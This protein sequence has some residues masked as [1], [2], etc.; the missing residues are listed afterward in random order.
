[1]KKQISGVPFLAILFAV[2]QAIAQPCNEYWFKIQSSTTSQDSIKYLRS[3][4]NSNCK[5]SLDLCWFNLARINYLHGGADSS[6]L[7]HINEAIKIDSA[8]YKYFMLRGDIFLRFHS[9]RSALDDYRKSLYLMRYSSDEVSKALVSNAIGGTLIDISMESD[10]IEKENLL[11]EAILHLNQAISLYPNFDYAYHLLGVASFHLEN[12]NASINA[13]E[14]CRDI[15][16]QREHLLKCLSIAYQQAG[17]F[18]GEKLYKLD[19]AVVLLEKAYEI[20]SLDIETIRL[21]GVANG[22]KGNKDSALF[23]FKKRV[24]LVPNDADACWDLS[25]AYRELGKRRAMKKCK[26]KRLQ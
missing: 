9:Y 7:S 4:I 21:L 16:P 17:R 22:I 24:E 15:N 2:S 1:M 8:K 23:W 20:D 14:K 26:K 12:Y 19:S 25:I 3:Y 10:S 18:Y 5:D 6:S 11:N 13:F